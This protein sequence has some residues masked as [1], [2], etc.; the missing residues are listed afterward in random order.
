MWMHSKRAFSLLEV[1]IV[2]AIIG[3]LASIAFVASAPARE[4]AR[5][6]V[7]ASNLKQHYQA[8]QMYSADNPGALRLPGTDLGIPGPTLQSLEQYIR[9]P[10]LLYCPDYP[11]RFQ[12]PWGSS[13]VWQIM[14]H[15]DSMQKDEDWYERV[16]A[17][18]EQKGSSY[19]IVYCTVH[20]IVFYYP[21][22]IEQ[23]GSFLD[24]FHIE[25]RSDGSVRAHRTPGPRLL[26]NQHPSFHE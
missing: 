18:L 19:P 15:S 1:L 16:R 4:R 12:H 11:K 21:R 5:Q 17:S 2:T 9:D 22:E 20:D 7:C 26:P 24:P 13:Y 3:I 14:A 10:D 23:G 6:A 25:L 8:I